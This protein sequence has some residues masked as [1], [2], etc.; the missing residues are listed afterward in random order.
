MSNNNIWVD[1]QTNIVFTPDSNGIFYPRYM[2]F[3]IQ[4]GEIR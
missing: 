4:T 2:N 3:N 1:K